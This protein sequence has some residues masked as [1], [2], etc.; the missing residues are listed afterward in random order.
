M[1]AAL[2]AE[3]ERREGVERGSRQRLA[4]L[5][6]THTASITLAALLRRQTPLQPTASTALSLRPKHSRSLGATAGRRLPSADR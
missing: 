5:S 2:I 1:G 3:A 4:W 6:T